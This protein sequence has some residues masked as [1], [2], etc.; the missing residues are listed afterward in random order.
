MTSKSKSIITLIRNLFLAAIFAFSGVLLSGMNNADVIAMSE[1]GLD[2]ETIIVAIKNSDKNSF[3]TGAQSLIALNNAGVSNEVIRYM[4]NP[5]AAAN[6]AAP[7]KVEATSSFQ[8][9]DD[10]ESILPGPITP[11]AGETYYTRFTLHFERKSWPATNYARGTLVP[12]NSEVKLIS[13]SGSVVKLLLVDEG[14]EVSFK[15]IKKYT[16]TDLN[17][18]AQLLLSSEPTAIGEYGEEIASYI[19]EGELKLGMTKQQVVL[20]RGYPPKHVT[21]SLNQSRWVYWSSRF[22]KRTLVFDDDILSEGRGL[23]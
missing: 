9:L 4:I 21:D 22:V 5:K 16:E 23:D 7:K 10:E 12:I 1:A 11:Q 20:T 3:E 8:V 17:G 19:R 18:F 6:T 15:N 14:A 2:D 13:M